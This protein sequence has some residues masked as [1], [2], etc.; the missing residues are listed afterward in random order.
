MN[1]FEAITSL[2]YPLLKTIHA[3]VGGYE[4]EPRPLWLWE[5][6]ILD[7]YDVFRCLRKFRKGV[8][9]ADLTER[10]IVFKPVP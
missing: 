2:D 3:Q 6:A 10:S 1:Y 4:V 5:K 9:I 8:V 7:G